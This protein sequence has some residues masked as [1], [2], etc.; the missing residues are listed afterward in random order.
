M[1]WIGQHIWDYI[2]RFRNDVYLEDVA[3]SAQDHVV[4]ID[5]NGKLYKQDVSVGDITGVTAG[6]ALTGGGDT[7]AITINHEDTSSQASVDNSGRTYI[8]DIT[9]DTYGHV[10]GLTS[11]TETVT[12]TN[13]TYTAGTGLDLGGT[14]FTVDVSDFMTNGVDNRIVTA[15]GTDAMNAEANLTWDG[16]DFTVTSTTTARP[17]VYIKATANHAKPPH[18]YFVKDKGAA[19]ANGDQP[20][21]IAFQGDNADQTLRTFAQIITFATEVTAGDEAGQISLEVAS[22]SGTTSVSK[23]AFTAIGSSSAYQVDTSIGSGTSSTATI[24][25]N[26]DVQGELISSR[27][28]LTV[29]PGGTLE[30]D[31]TGDMTL[32][33]SADIELNADGGQINFKDGSAQLAKIS[34]DGLSFVDN[35]G[36]GIIFE[37]TT[38]DAY[39]TTLTAADTTSSSKTITLPDATGTV[40]LTNGH[41]SIIR[42][43]FWSSSTSGYYITLGGGSTSESSSLASS[44]YTTVFNCPFDG[45]VKRIAASTQSSGSK[46]VKLEMYID[47]DDSDLVADQ[48][49]SDWN[50]SSYTNAWCEDSPG[51]WTFSKGENIAIK[52]T[53]SAAVYGTQYSIVLEFD[54]TT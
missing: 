37:G 52:A 7:G 24:A 4:G 23:N 20:G 50:V 35:T 38:D 51:D 29:T 8:Q 6:D 54:L 53:D 13:T 49:G 42:A 15:T 26:L 36:A 40:A 48:R 47:K 5:A 9:L 18:L 19:G 30:I 10:T 11:A 1:K 22:S 44:S 17:D 46:T 3:E 31:S 27:T 33:S 34:A 45:K 2:S 14:E 12:D 39:N 21:L 25:G 41:I 28:N 16:N 43:S 32:D